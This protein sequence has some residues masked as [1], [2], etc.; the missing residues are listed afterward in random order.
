MLVRF[1]RTIF[2][3]FLRNPLCNDA[4][5]FPLKIIGVWD[6]STACLSGRIVEN[7]GVMITFR[8][9][10]D[11]CSDLIVVDHVAIQ[12]LSRSAVFE[13]NLFSTPNLMIHET[14]IRKQEPIVLEPAFNDISSLVDAARA[15][16]LHAANVGLIDLY[17]GIGQYLS[18]RCASD[19]WG[20]GTVDS[21][22]A[23]IR[24]RRPEWRGFSAPNL[25]RM[26]QFFDLY[27]GDQELSTLLR[28]LPWSANLHIVS[29]CKSKE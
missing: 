10:G 11:I 14:M 9:G 18:T 20:K 4:I 6:G 16:V 1:R 27:D 28:E 23:L 19:G 3:V 22:A 24:S 17:W 12:V 25:W 26:K 21:L 8:R 15:R 29:K 2:G 5:C 7:G 13:T